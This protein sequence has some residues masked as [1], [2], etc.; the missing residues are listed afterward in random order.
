[1]QSLK[2]NEDQLARAAAPAD[3]LRLLQDRA[4]LL[5]RR[6]SLVESEAVLAAADKLH[7]VVDD[8]CGQLRTRYARAVHDYFS[9]QFKKATNALLEVLDEAR[10]H[11]PVSYTHLTLP[12]TSRV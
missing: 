4:V 5:A 12:T 6:E 7:A 8:A 1:M 11:C 9:R 10:D 2:D 3:R